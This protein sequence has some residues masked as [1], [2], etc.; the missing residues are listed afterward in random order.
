MN[1]LLIFLVKPYGQ[2]FIVHNNGYENRTHH[3]IQVKFE[4]FIWKNT[5]YVVD[6]DGV[7]YRL[8]ETGKYLHQEFFNNEFSEP[9]F[10]RQLQKSLFVSG[11]VSFGRFFVDG[12]KIIHYNG[13]S[14]RT[15]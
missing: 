8:K 13:E 7:I 15:S 14:V 11:I 5:L 9:E 1:Q 12:E 6:F 4:P 3:S 10:I 2:S